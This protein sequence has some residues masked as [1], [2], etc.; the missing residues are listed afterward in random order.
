MFSRDGCLT[1]KIGD[2]MHSFTSLTG[3]ITC[4]IKAYHHTPIITMKTIIAATT[5]ATAV[6]ASQQGLE[7]IQKDGLSSD[8][9]MGRHLLANARKLEDGNAYNNNYDDMS[10]VAGFS[11]KFLGCNTV[12]QWVNENADN[13][14]D[15]NNNNQNADNGEMTAAMDPTN[16]KIESVGLVRF[17]LCPRDHC[18]DHFG[19]GCSQHYGEYVVAMSTFLET[20]LSYEK[21]MSEQGCEAYRETCYT[22]CDQSNKALCY[23]NCYKGYGINAAFCASSDGNGNYYDGMFDMDSAIQCTQ[24]EYGGEDGYQHWLGPQCSGQ[25]GV[26]T[27]GL[28]DDE[29]CQVA[30]DRQPVY[31]QKNYGAPVTPHTSDSIVST[32]CMSCL[33]TDEDAANQDAEY[34]NY[35]ADGNK[36]YYE[37][38]NVNSLCA[39]AYLAAGKCENQIDSS[40]VLYP[41]EGACTYLEGVKRLKDDGIIRGNETVTSKPASIAIGFFTGAACLLAGYVG[42]LKH[43]IQKSRVNLAGVTTSLA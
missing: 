23:Y 9:A 36:N 26:I 8:S 19:V 2:W 4:N 38:D 15:N 12:T 21:E 37:S 5:L 1:S 25:G 10:W 16:G 30:S 20:Y 3:I 22:K 11:I 41:E 13:D 24:Y 31:Y 28:F 42:Y 33:A 35:D 32:N 40:S 14:D 43:K 34:Y 39:T 6:A 18:F 7:A 29:D 27:L 17:R